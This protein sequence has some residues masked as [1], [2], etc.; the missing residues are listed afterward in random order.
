MISSGIRLGTILF[1]AIILCLPV[2]VEAARPTAEDA[3][4]AAARE[5]QGDVYILSGGFGVFST[6]LGKLKTQLQ[7]KGVVAS[8]VS[9]QGWRRISRKIV[10]NRRQY[11][12]KPVVIIGHSLG[13]NNTILIADALNKKGIQV[14]LIVSYAA[15]A[16]MTVPSN[17]RN[18]FNYYFASGGWGAI[19]KGESGF[20]GR[21]NNVDVSNAGIGHFTVDDSPELR[22]EVVR[23]VLRYVRQG[24]SATVVDN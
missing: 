24:K 2:R 13:A 20:A 7:E 18:V 21:L 8:L 1:L 11:G 22:D 10:E 19:F 3:P 14:D 6:G 4:I 17:V 12:R 15:T 16:P 9:H 23:N 5:F